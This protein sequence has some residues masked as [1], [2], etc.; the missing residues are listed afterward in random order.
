[1]SDEQPL[2]GRI[3]R[4]RRRANVAGGRQHAHRVLVTAEEEEQLVRRAEAQRV[5]V[6]RLLVESALSAVRRLVPRIDAVIDGLADTS[7]EVVR[8]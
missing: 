3:G 2:L 5:T 1:M 4:R 6:P 8:R 7:R